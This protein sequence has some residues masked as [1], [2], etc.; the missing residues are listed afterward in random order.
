VYGLG[1]EGSQRDLFKYFVKS[2]GCRLANA[3]LNVPEDVIDLL[4]RRRF[5][6]ALK[7]TFAVNEDIAVMPKST[8][9]G[10][11]GKGALLKH[12]P[13][14]SLAAPSGFTWS[15]HASWFTVFY[16][17]NVSPNGDHGSTWIANAQHVYLGSV[18][19]VPEELRDE[20]SARVRR[21]SQENV[22]ATEQQFKA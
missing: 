21:L 17:Y 15:E 5:E 10:F 7:L 20:F 13:R 3:N 4:P 14:S 2:F 9:D 22:S 1:F 12:T 8:R 6:T 16:W 18:S 11:I 19:P